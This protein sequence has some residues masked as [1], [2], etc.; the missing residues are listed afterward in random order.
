MG[1]SFLVGKRK[2]GP[3]EMKSFDEHF[4]D[5]LEFKSQFGHTVVPQH[6]P[7]LGRWVKQMRREFKLMKEG[8]R[9]TM[10]PEKVLK[11]AD[12]GFVFDAQFRRGSKI[13]TNDFTKVGGKKL[14]DQG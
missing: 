3:I 6:Y 4:Q 10:T 1:F 14:G 5:L 9:S 12:I 2:T 8:K 11:L 13:S 7:G